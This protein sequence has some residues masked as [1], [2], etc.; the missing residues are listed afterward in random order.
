MAGSEADE[1]E[2]SPGDI[3]IEVGG[4]DVRS[5]D[6]ET[7]RQVIAATADELAIVVQVGSMLR[8]LIH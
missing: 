5:A 1:Q 7:V 4:V 2:L 3:I 6:T 8:D